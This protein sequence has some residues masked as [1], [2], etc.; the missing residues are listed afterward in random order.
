MEHLGYFLAHYFRYALVLTL[1]VVLVVF[2]LRVR[3]D[4]QLTDER[5]KLAMKQA[6]IAATKPLRTDLENTQRKITLI[7]NVL[8]KQEVLNAQIDYVTQVIPKK[9]T[10][11]S[12][13]INEKQVQIEAM[14]SDYT[15]IQ[16]FISR[17]N[18]D[19]RFTKVQANKVQKE[20]NQQYSFSITLE[21]YKTKE[22][23]KAE[24][25]KVN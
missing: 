20:G 22:D 1:F 14:T 25:Q 10:I 24:I 2:F 23:K 16:L 15:I 11:R 18:K 4:Q 9:S 8:A 3:V 13:L 6:I 5:E 17:L 21:G 12:V 7:K 19:A